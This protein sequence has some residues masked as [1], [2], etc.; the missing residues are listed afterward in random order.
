MGKQSMT[1]TFEG[2][3]MQD[4]VEKIIEFLH[5]IG[6]LKQSND[7]GETNGDDTSRKN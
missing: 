6:V 1:V 2:D 7:G 3:N 5:S 4:M